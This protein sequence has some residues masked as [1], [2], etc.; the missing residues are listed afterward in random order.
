M[1]GRALSY[2]SIAAK[3]GKIKSGEYQTESAIRSNEAELV[4]LTVDAS[5][6]TKK[7][8]RNMTSYY[9][10]PLSEICT[11]EKLGALIGKDMRSCA[12]ITD[13]N[14]AAAF[15]DKLGNM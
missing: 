2:L 8:I 1:N 4:I 11:K 12:A 5:E 9:K 14:L 7:K 10:V 6:G 13:G 3:A 15:L